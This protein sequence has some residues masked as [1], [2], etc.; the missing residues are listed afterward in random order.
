M[1]R[2]SRRQPPPVAGELVPGGGS[3]AV[4]KSPCP[5]AQLE[6]LLLPRIRQDQ[7]CKVHLAIIRAA[8]DSTSDFAL[9]TKGDSTICDKGIQDATEE[10]G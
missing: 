6:R 1:R 10:A 2:Q 7:D 8:S 9:V 4:S 5:V 3:P